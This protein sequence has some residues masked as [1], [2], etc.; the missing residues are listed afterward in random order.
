MQSQQRKQMI[1][2]GFDAVAPGY[3]HPSL[4]FFPDTAQ[5]LVNLLQLEPHLHLLD[6]CTGTGCVAIEAAQQLPQGQVIGIDLS[7]GMLQQ[8]RNKAAEKNSLT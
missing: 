7:N 2:Q 4:A 8:A 1:Q 3:D 6:V 5:R